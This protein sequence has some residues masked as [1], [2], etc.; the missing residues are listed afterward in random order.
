MSELSISN[1]EPVSVPSYEE[2]C[3][4]QDDDSDWWHWLLEDHC[5]HLDDEYGIDIAP[6]DISCDLYRREC[7]ST[8]RISDRK[9]FVKAHYDALMS[10]SPV[11]TQVLLEGMERV[12][13]GN[14]HRNCNVAFDYDNE[15]AGV[16]YTFTQGL[17]IGL[18]VDTLIEAEPHDNHYKWYACV[19]EIIKDVHSNIIKALECEDEYRKSK[20]E[21]EEWLKTRQ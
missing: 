2:F 18:D 3:E 14:S 15:Y 7:A 1:E 12:R 9:Q 16:G 10:A 20:E 8:G 11:L 21:Y 17:F 19:E 5:E 4:M 13:W 6:K